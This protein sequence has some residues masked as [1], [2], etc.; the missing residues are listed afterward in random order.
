MMSYSLSLYCWSWK[1]RVFTIPLT[2]KDT[3]DSTLTILPFRVSFCCPREASGAKR[4][5][6]LALPP[7]LLPSSIPSS[8]PGLL[9]A[10]ILFY[11]EKEGNV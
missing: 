10:L 9:H 8:D 7:G 2:V 4:K 11:R 1:T 5:K 6:D 3:K